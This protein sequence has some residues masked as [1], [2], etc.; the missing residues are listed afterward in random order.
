[1]KNVKAPSASKE[2]TEALKKIKKLREYKDAHK[3]R[4]C[5]PTEPVFPSPEVSIKPSAEF[6]EKVSAYELVEKILPHNQISNLTLEQIFALKNYQIKANCSYCDN[7]F[8]AND[9]CYVSL[10]ERTEKPIAQSEIEKYHQQWKKY[11]FSILKYAKE[12]EQHVNEAK[13]KEEEKEKKEFL[14]LRD[15][16]GSEFGPPGRP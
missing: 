13:A 11:E 2:Y 4:K 7:E 5:M 16:Y 14:R 9:E 3:F 1:M 6:S 10:H 15:K 12:L 8:D